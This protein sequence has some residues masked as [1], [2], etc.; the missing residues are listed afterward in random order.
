MY[1]P[2]IDMR[3]Q[4]NKRGKKLRLLL[5][6]MI[7]LSLVVIGGC[8][9]KTIPNSDEVT[10]IVFIDDLGR[11]VSMNVPKKVAILSG[12]LADAWLLAGGALHAITEDAKELIAVT[13]DM[14]VVGS[15][16]NPSME[17][18][19]E[20]DIEFAILSA[21]LAEHVNLMNNLEA[22]GITTAY[23]DVETFDDYA[24]MMRILTDMTGRADL[25]DQHV[26]A[27][28][29][30]IDEQISR[31]KNE[32]SPK[33]LFLRAFSTGVRAKGSDSMTG[34]MLQDLG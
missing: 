17:L 23:F 31:G 33:V 27:I 22:V 7:C 1:E 18:L 2:G 5:G 14:R 11:E 25:Y 4:I 28:A 8:S 10:P 26:E 21:A 12:S 32:K 9:N 3:K 13:D 15:L 24:N 16:K 29:S 6:L 30:Q 34:A 20:E 19:I